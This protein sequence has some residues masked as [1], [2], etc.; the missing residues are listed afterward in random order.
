MASQVQERDSKWK[1]ALEY[2]I[3]FSGVALLCAVVVALAQESPAGA[4]ISLDAPASQYSNLVATGMKN[5][6]SEKP[7]GGFGTFPT[8]S[9]S[10]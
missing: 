8:P 6:V 2:V 4:G 9:A 7:V 10:D 3:L 5:A 1:A